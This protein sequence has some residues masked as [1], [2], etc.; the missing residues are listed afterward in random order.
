[1]PEPAM[2]RPIIDS[3]PLS[4]A[5]A[6]K[7][8]VPTIQAPPPSRVPKA[9]ST[10]QSGSVAERPTRGAATS[11]GSATRATGKEGAG[12]AR[13]PSRDGSAVAT[14]KEGAGAGKARPPSRGASG[15]NAV[16]A[17]PAGIGSAPA[18]AAPSRAAPTV[19]GGAGPRPTVGALLRSPAAC[20]RP[21]SAAKLP[22]SAAVGSGGYPATNG[23]RPGI[24]A[25]LG[26]DDAADHCGGAP[27]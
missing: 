3:P 22:K 17:S 23:S 26:A 8:T 20:S 4:A 13:P 14:G 6:S 11:G 25:L 7:S 16:A 24:S 10:T 5:S 27:R 21:G 9:S 19:A 15:V 18:A 1:M 2:S 12:K